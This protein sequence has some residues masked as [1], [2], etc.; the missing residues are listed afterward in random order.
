MQAR[1]LILALLSVVVLSQTP[2]LASRSITFYVVSDTNTLVIGPDVSCVSNAVATWVHPAW[3]ANIPGATWIW[4]SYQVTS[5]TTQQTVTFSTSFWVF[6]SPAKANLDLAADNSV[7]TSING[8]SAGCQSTDGS[9][10]NQIA[11]DVTAYVKTG[12][13]TIT[14]TLVNYAADGG[15]PTGNPAGLLFKLTVNAIA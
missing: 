13:N 3:T 8:A 9:F 10:S 11:C 1:L 12:L 5:P 2:S 4:D 6:G 7:T 15:T 14:F